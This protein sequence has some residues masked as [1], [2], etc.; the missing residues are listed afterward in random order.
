MNDLRSILSGR[1]PRLAVPGSYR[2]VPPEQT[3]EQIR[4]YLPRAGITRLANI[5]GLDRLGVPVTLA[6]RPNGRVLSVSSGKGLTLPAA[7]VSG[8]MEALE[9]QHAEVEWSPATVRR[10]YAEMASEHVVPQRSELPLARAAPFPVD[11]P[12]LWTWGWDL[13]GCV[14]VAVP[15]SMVHMGNR[16]SRIFDLWAFQ[17]TSNGLA[18]GNNMIEAIHSAL[19]EV[20][21]RDAV[22]CHGERRQRS[23]VPPPVVDLTTIDF[24]LVSGLLERL[25]R[26][27]VSTVLF[28]C[29]I[30]TGVP[31]YMANIFEPDGQLPGIFAGYGANLDPQVAMIRAVTEAVQARTVTI[32]GSRDDLHRHR[33]VR[34]QVT[35]QY[36]PTWLASVAQAPVVATPP[37]P[38]RPAETFEAEVRV[39]LEHLRAA[40]LERVI[41]LDLS[42]PWCPVSV[43]K[44]VVPG[45]EGYRAENF[46]PGGRARN[47]A[48]ASAGGAP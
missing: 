2:T 45:L 20:I 31:V 29:T 6:V 10:S 30:D 35:T 5:T 12:Y 25:D 22:T 38:P 34:S 19:L 24:P 17:V 18:S 7:L 15:V 46:V 9:L 42:T 28:D 48:M 11:W 39:L 3:L 4:P 40:G 14:D 41:V 26:A 36:V 43:A 27:D 8:A 23:G 1:T 21:E 33:A 13:V 32:A 44:V 16:H 37:V 47:F